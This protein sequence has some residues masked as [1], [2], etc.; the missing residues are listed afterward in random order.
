MDSLLTKSTLKTALIA[1][2]A[3]ALVTR[4]SPDARAMLLNQDG[5][6]FT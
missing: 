4:F 1:L 3:V 2:A 5:D 6:Y